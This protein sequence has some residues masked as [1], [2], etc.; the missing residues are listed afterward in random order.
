MTYVPRKDQLVEAVAP[1]LK[2]GDVVV[3][4][5]AGDIGQIGRALYERLG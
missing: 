3:V 2:P 5:G 4:L 1:Q